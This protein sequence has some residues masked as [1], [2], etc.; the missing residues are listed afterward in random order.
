MEKDKGGAD[1]NEGV[2]ST[3]PQGLSN[4]LPKLIIYHYSVLLWAI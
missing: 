4:L 1:A 2:E 3:L